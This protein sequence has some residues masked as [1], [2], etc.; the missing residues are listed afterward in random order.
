MSKYLTK[1]ARVR[2]SGDSSD[3]WI[4]DYNVRVST[5]ATVEEDVRGPARKVL[6]TLDSIDGDNNVL[7]RVR[8][9]RLLPV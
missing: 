6:V 5:E 9:S 4:E 8:R 1:G 2:V 3:L 7:T